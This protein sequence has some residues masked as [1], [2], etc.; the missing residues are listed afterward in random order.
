M[1]RSEDVECVFTEHQR[2]EISGLRVD[3]WKPS[4]TEDPQ[5]KRFVT[6]DVVCK[7]RRA[8]KTAQDRGHE[9]TQKALN[10]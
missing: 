8:V 1:A 3:F 2:F 7:M 6:Y 9:K 5:A 4:E 10:L